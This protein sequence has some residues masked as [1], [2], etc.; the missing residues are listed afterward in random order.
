MLLQHFE[1]S[2]PP[3]QPT[4]N[5]E[6]QSDVACGRKAF[7]NIFWFLT[8]SGVLPVAAPWSGHPEKNFDRVWIEDF[9]REYAMTHTK[10]G[11][12]CLE[13]GI[14]YTEEFFGQVCQIRDALEYG[15]P[16]SPV[17]HATGTTFYG[18]VHSLP[19]EMSNTFDILII[20]QVHEHLWNPMKAN[21]ELFR[22]LKPGGLVYVTAPHISVFHG[23]PDDFYRYT[24]NGLKSIF[25]DAGFECLLARPYGNLGTTVAT[26][27]GFDVDS[28]TTSEKHYAPAEDGLYSEVM[29]I[30]KKPL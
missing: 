23:V 17:T 4:V 24:V 14:H 7:Q 20:T 5:T 12:R 30:F 18:D 11:S 1:A 29:G 10:P 26:I 28:Y 16:R 8:K 6:C 27:M 15:G 25:M 21:K 9:F 3:N 2:Q 13:W 19:E 22:I